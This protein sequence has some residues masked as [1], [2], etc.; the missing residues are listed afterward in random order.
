MR[1]VIRFVYVPALGKWRRA[2]YQRNNEQTY[3][4]HVGL[5]LNWRAF[6]VGWH[7]SEHHRRLCVNVL[8][9]ITIYYVKPGGVIP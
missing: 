9:C 8:P 7:Y 5:L 3:A 2:L 6:W 1:R 4:R